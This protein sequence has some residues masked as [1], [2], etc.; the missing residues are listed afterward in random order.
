MSRL[1]GTQSERVEANL[2]MPGAD[3]AMLERWFLTPGE[4][5][6]PYTDI[7]ARH[8]GNAAWT[9]GNLVRPLVHGATYFSE[10]LAGLARMRAGDQLML[11]DWRGDPDE[12]LGGPGTEVAQVLADAAR[13]GI[14]VRALLWRSHLDWFHYH[15]A[16]NR[17]IGEEIH[18]AG[19]DCILDMRVPGGGSHHR[20]IVIMRQLAST[21][22]A[23]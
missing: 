19:G 4:R 16:E 3:R 11:T 1:P 12:E 22:A 17:K 23:P 14:V 20:K 10:L 2:T 9:T 21:T 6:N 8:P 18:A 7:D 13:R 5:G 15:E